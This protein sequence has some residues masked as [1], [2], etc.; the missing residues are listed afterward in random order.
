VPE[1]SHS[2]NISWNIVYTSYVVSGC[3]CSVIYVDDSDDE[4]C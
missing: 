4:N 1:L 3:P 2:K